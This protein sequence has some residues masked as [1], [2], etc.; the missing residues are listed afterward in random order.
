V[1]LQGASSGNYVLASTTLS[2]AIGTI[3]KKALTA[4]LTG[5][6]TKAY[7]GTTAATLSASNYLLSGVILTDAGLVALNTPT[8]GTYDTAAKGT[9]KTVTVTGLGLLGTAAGNYTLPTTTITGR[10]GVIQ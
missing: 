1:S 3:V 9:G 8:S 2:A 6:V 4:S 10:V 5:T 7:D